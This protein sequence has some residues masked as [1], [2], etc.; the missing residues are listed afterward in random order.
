MILRFCIYIQSQNENE[1]QLQMTE[2]HEIELDNDRNQNAQ[3]ITD[4]ELT[5]AIDIPSNCSDYNNDHDDVNDI[6]CHR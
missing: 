2:G 6:D 3:Y 1:M 5:N 4:N